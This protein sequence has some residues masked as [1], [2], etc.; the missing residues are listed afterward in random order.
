MYYRQAS[1]SVYV[2][3]SARPGVVATLNMP[4]YFS[5][6]ST[7][8]TAHLM[9]TGS[10]SFSLRARYIDFSDASMEMYYYNSVSTFLHLLAYTTNATYLVWSKP[11]SGLVSMPRGVFDFGSTVTLT[12]LQFTSTS[13]SFSQNMM[14]GLVTLLDASARVETSVPVNTTLPPPQA[15]S[16]GTISVNSSTVK[17]YL[18][19][20][21]TDSTGQGL[22][23]ALDFGDP[24]GSRY[25]A[26][27][28]LYIAGKQRGISY[29]VG[30]V[31]TDVY[32]RQ[33]SSSVYVIE[34]ARTGA[35]GTLS[36]QVGFLSN[37]AFDLTYMGMPTFSIRARYMDFSDTT[38]YVDRKSVV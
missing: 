35:T 26:G 22:T 34:S 4:S 36:V 15:T 8:A 16:I 33:E 14:N 17:I 27:S 3:E 38:G 31:A 2:T 13:T 9:Y 20:Y 21:F 28:Y 1:S 7:F 12:R 23:Y 25:I 19:D 18:P 6:Y 24:S 30:V 29:T 11:V 5:W 10:I 32:S 37:A